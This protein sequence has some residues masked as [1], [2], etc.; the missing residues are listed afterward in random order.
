MAFVE[1]RYATCQ[2]IKEMT[3]DN[4]IIFN[5]VGKKNNQTSV[6]RPEKKC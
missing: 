4:L 6:C 2:K 5:V 1:G 3:K